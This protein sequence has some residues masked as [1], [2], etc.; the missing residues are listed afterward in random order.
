MAKALKP[1]VIVLLVLSI[2]SLVLG[3]L[4]FL[5]RGE[6]KDRV[7]KN[8][9]AIV[10]IAGN[11]HMDGLDAAKL[12]EQLKDVKAMQ[13]A[14]DGVAVSAENRYEELQNTKTDLEN[15]RADLTKTKEELATTKTELSAAQAK[16]TELTDNL[17]RK[18]AEVAQA[19]SEI[20]QLQQDKTALQTQIADLNEQLSKAQDEMKDLQDQVATLDKIVK[21]STPTT[22]NK[23]LP[24]GLSGKIAVVNS[25]WNFVVLNIGSDSGLV[26]DAQMLVHRADKFIGKVRITNVQKSMAIADIVMDWEQSPI[27]EGDY[28]LY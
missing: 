4:L 24:I 19:K 6:I 9:L 14:L 26:R 23:P 11:L 1:L 13:L 16:V 8:E 17:A 15:T 28:V 25:D 5:Q 10:K 22:G 20:D 12:A 27:Q 18:E 7:Q 2:V 21:E 3:T